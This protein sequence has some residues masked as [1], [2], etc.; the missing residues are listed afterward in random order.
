MAG[1]YEVIGAFYWS[2]AVKVGDMKGRDGD[3]INAIIAAASYNFGLLLR[4]PSFWAAWPR[5]SSAHR[6]SHK[7]IDSHQA[8]EFVIWRV[9]PHCCT[10][11]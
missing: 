5:R 11:D 2:G 1:V 10:V 3:R 8:T 7:P 4:W 9:G 6:S